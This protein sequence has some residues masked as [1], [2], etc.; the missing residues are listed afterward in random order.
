MDVGEEG[1]VSGGEGWGIFFCEVWVNIEKIYY[2]C[3][4]FSQGNAVRFG[5]STRCCNFR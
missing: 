4:R 3:I 5:N 2:L 1:G